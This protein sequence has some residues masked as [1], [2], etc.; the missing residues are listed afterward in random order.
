MSGP[1]QW[2][3]RQDDSGQAIHGVI[4]AARDWADRPRDQMLAIFEEQIRSTFPAARDAKLLRGKVVVEKRATFSPLPGVDRARPSQLPPPDGLRNLFL[5]G[6]YT[7][8][9]WPATMEG[10]VRS[11]YL[12]AE[13]VTRFLAPAM[14]RTP[15]SFLTSDLP[16]ES[17][18][19]LFGPSR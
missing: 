14:Q 19:R 15:R 18:A 6:D 5:A 7:L 1:L 11:G 3:F 2:V 10:A 12:A 8:T 17:P 13:A 9:G 16:I 4:S